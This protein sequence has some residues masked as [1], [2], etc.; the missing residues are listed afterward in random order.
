MVLKGPRPI[1][2]S[3]KIYLNKKNIRASLTISF[4]QKISIF[5]WKINLFFL[6]KIGIRV[7]KLA[8]KVINIII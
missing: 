8:L 3:L 5:S 2:V 7:A 6:G 4:F 1:F